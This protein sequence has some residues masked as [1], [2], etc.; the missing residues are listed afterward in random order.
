MWSFAVGAVLFFLFWVYHRRKVSRLEEELIST[1]NSYQRDLLQILEEPEAIPQNLEHF[2]MLLS[3]GSRRTTPHL[4]L[5]LVGEDHKRL[6]DL[7]WSVLLDYLICQVA[8]DQLEWRKYYE[9]G[10]NF[11]GH[12]AE[13]RL[14]EEDCVRVLV[15]HKENKQASDTVGLMLMSR[16]E[17]FR[18]SHQSIDM[19]RWYSHSEERKKVLGLVQMVRFRQSGISLP[20]LSRMRVETPQRTLLIEED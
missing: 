8:Q 4:L 18:S 7:Y 1:R 3:D 6:E 5:D 13:V 2:D 19:I 16:A 14:S 9:A 12:L 17:D 20:T 10:L 11:N 15:V